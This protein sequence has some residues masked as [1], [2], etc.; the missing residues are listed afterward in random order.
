MFIFGLLSGCDSS[1]QENTATTTAP[2][3]SEKSTSAELIEAAPEYVGSQQCASCHSQ[4]GQEWQG[5][6]HDLAMQPADTSTVLGDFNNAKFVYYGIESTFYKREN[7]FYV[8]TDGPDGQLTEYPIA[9]TFGVDPLQQY[10]IAFPDGRLQALNI[11]WDTRAKENGGQRWFHLHPDEPIKYSD[12]LHWTGINYNWN[13]MCADCHSTNLQKAYDETTNTYATTWSEIDVG[14]EACHGPAS[15][16]LQWTITSTSTSK[17][18]ATIQNKGFAQ[19]F[20]ERKNVAWQFQAGSGIAQRNHPKTTNKEINTCASCHSRRGT[21]Y[22]HARPSDGFLNSFQPALLDDPLYHA[23]GQ[24]NEEVYVYGS[25]L[26]SKMYHAG[27]TCSDCHN[28]HNLELKAE[29]NRVC[30]QCHLPAQFDT[31]DHHLHSTGSPGSQCV[32]CHMPEKNFM[33]VDARNDHS[34]RIPR[35][36]ISADLGTPNAC[37]QCHSDKEPQWAAKVLEDKFGKPESNHYAYAIAAG[38]YGWPDTDQR[39]AQLINDTS[40]PE[41][42]RATAVSLLTN[43]LS[44]S[45]IPV[46]Q[47]VAQSYSPLMSLALARSADRL[48]D[49]YRPALTL[50]LLFDPSKVT[51]GLTASALSGLPM[52]QFPADVQKRLARASEDYLV[53]SNFNADRPEVLTNLGGYY[54][55]QGLFEEAQDYFHKAVTIAPYYTPAYIN[56]AD[57]QRVLGDESE[58]QK[59]LQLALDKVRNKAA[60]QHALGLSLVREQRVE[61]AMDYLRQAA[62]SD[63]DTGRY[64]YVYAIALHSS[65]K[66]DHALKVL[67]EARAKFPSDREIIAALASINRD[68]GRESQAKAYETDKKSGIAP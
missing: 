16:H 43:Y 35:P 65:G 10:L 34:F 53:S 66:S 63:N 15:L 9:Y 58:A 21:A 67:D 50:P 1:T 37:N 12:E 60:V 62:E 31:Q 13:H 29:G 14:C 30:A 45:T 17:T 54:A 68:L 22:P 56:L 5:S 19:S 42:A 57:L 46:L 39:L 20:D 55:K 48:P 28:P 24:V 7:R 38:R 36:D 2:I 44:N 26:Q 23:D 3:V 6:H 59:V 25:F 64:A 27:V 32:N 18:D 41:I 33:V 40:Q 11:V 4:Q 8:S 49:Q 61:E 47:S 51:R 52:E